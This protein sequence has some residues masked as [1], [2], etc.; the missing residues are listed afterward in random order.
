[1][2]G[3]LISLLKQVNR[4]DT[5]SFSID[6]A[7][8]W[9][10]VINEAMQNGVA[11]YLYHRLKQTGNL[12]CVPAAAVDLLRGSYL[13]A[14]LNHFRVRKTLLDVLRCLS[15]RGIHAL[16]LKG[17]YLA[18]AVYDQGGLRPMGDLDILVRHDQ[19]APATRVLEDLGYRT[20]DADRASSGWETLHHLPQFHKEEQITIELHWCIE[21]P[22]LKLDVSFDDLIKNEV[23]FKVADQIA[24]A[25]GVVD[26]LLHLCCHWAQHHL[27]LTGLRPAVDLAVYLEHFG[28]DLNWD[29]LYETAE[30]WQVVRL[31]DLS[32]QTADELV[33]C[34]I[35]EQIRLRWRKTT[36]DQDQ[37]KRLALELVQ[38]DREAL[39]KYPT[40]LVA[41]ME[42]PA[43][44][45]LFQLL[46]NR[47]FPS[48]A[49]MSFYYPVS[50]RSWRI[51][52]YYPFRWWFLIS[53]YSGRF[54]TN[55]LQKI[56][57]DPV[58]Q[59]SARIVEL[60][61]QLANALG[62]PLGLA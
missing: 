37:L 20:L 28:E 4:S 58:L 42:Q 10:P 56:T 14:T 2:P 12:S 62:I 11:A 18:E 50:A 52:F 48:P 1:M 23:Q 41:A 43:L 19:L 31:L 26:C 47:F 36:G 49:E 3:A 51:W 34:R 7:F 44:K 33:G 57:V 5:A 38:C 60:Q 39:T 30:Q 61:S 53:N 13:S 8:R 17:G 16:V 35:P 46:F 55:R 45:E 9:E 29:L 32:L 40:N 54:F 27:F 21:R 22:N 59:E 25:P 6:P 24:F 15:E